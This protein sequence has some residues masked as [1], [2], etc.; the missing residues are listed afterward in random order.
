[1]LHIE[2]NRCDGV[3]K[4]IDDQKHCIR[5]PLSYRTV[6][7]P[8]H[9]EFIEKKSRFLCL[10]TP[11]TSEAE[12]EEAV[13]SVR[14]V[15]WEASHHCVAYR[16]RAG[17]E[18]ALDNGEPS[19]TAG[20]PMLHV[21]QEQDLTDVLAIVTRYFGGTKLGAGGLV[22]AYTQAVAQ[23][24]QLAHRVDYVPYDQ[25]EC[26]LSYPAYE[27]ALRLLQRPGWYVT[28]SFTDQVGLCITAPSAD[29]ETVQ[30]LI[31]A[32]TKSEAI[33]EPTMTFLYPYSPQTQ[34]AD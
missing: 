28:P 8:V 26:I 5:L 9:S 34:Q 31:A 20:R 3:V 18:R 1:M 23:A 13:A 14:K 6:A 27:S 7:Q 24:A 29:R 2:N 4:L 15:H 25:F 30:P 11:V 19:G 21:L 17:I 16:L 33:C 22:R 12:V 10:L 32:L